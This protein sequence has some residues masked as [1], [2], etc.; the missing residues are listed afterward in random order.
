[1]RFNAMYVSVHSKFAYH[2]FYMMDGKN[3]WLKVK[4][5][6]VVLIMQGIGL[7]YI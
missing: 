5:M 3:Q 2:I 6:I 1:M 7:C 4:T